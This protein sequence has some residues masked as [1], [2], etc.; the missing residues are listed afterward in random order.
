MVAALAVA[1]IVNK[2]LD[3]VLKLQPSYVRS[4][5]AALGG[6]A[7]A[8]VATAGM[9]AVWSKEKKRLSSSTQSTMRN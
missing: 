1:R 2:D 6:Q 9:E 8:S 3:S 7:A 5:E 4:L